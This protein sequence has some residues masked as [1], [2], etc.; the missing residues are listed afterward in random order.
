[1]ARPATG[2]TPV[3]NVRVSDALW[4]AAKARAAAEGKTVTD[5]IVAALH[6]YVSAPHPGAG[7]R[8]TDEA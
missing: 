4:E 6:R 7:T 5:V 8:R 1:M 2:K 3:R